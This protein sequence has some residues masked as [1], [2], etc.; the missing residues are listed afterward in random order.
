MGKVT[1]E[2]MQKVLAA[3][4]LCTDHI[5]AIPVMVSL[6]KSFPDHFAAIDAAFE[7]EYAYDAVGGVRVNLSYVVAHE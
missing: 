4:V 3:V 1:T 5:E 2:D 7:E 6:A